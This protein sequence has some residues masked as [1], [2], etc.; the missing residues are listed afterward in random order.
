MSG[1]DLEY[2]TQAIEEDYFD[3]GSYSRHISTESRAAQIWFDRGLIWAYAFNHE[4]SIKCFE[5][6]H[7]EDPASC[8]PLWGLAYSYGPNYNKPWEAFDKDE[9]EQNLQKAK[10]ALVKAEKLA[11]Q[12]GAT[13][14]ELVLVKA[15][16]KRY[17]DER[18]GEDDHAAWN[19]N[20][21][22]AMEEVY[23]EY[24]SDLD[25]AA[26]YADSLMNLTPV[27]HANLLSCMGADT[28]WPFFE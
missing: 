20:Y 19:A 11:G 10:D 16:Q 14:V 24:G 27:S 21:A 3:L 25:I 7:K 9:K 15:T 28:T 12:G 23:H 2:N 22:K 13:A 26:L 4:E 5:R 8:M 6:A 1:P 17:P 18:T